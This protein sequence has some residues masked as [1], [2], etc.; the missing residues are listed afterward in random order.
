MENANDDFCV[1]DMT[2]TL[3]SS[4]ISCSYMF[5]V[6]RV[7][8]LFPFPFFPYLFRAQ[9]NKKKNFKKTLKIFF[10]LSCWLFK[11]YIFVGTQTVCTS[12]STESKPISVNN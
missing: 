9:E 11:P 2:I 12:R 10:E 4:W 7:E 5:Q 1:E 3:V 8:F 6:C